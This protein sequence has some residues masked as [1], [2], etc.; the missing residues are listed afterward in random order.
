MNFEVLLRTIETGV[1]GEDIRMAIHDAL[2]YLNT[3]GGGGENNY[4]SSTTVTDIVTLTQ[5]AYDAIQTPSA[6]TLYVIYDT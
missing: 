6:T 2:S 4:V 1:Y 3:H 5:A